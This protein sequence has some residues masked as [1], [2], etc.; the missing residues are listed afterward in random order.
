MKISRGGLAVE[1]SGKLFAYSGIADDIERIGNHAVSVV[2]LVRDKRRGNIEFTKWAH[3]EIDEIAGLIVQN[4]EDTVTLLDGSS[5]EL[6]SRIFSREDR[7]DRLVREARK[8]HQERYHTG[9]CQPDAGPIFVEMILRLER[10][11][12][13]CENIAEYARE[14]K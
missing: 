8:R 4:L 3:A 2:G 11:S 5:S 6:V 1:L 10:M 13:H 12:D 7:V 9:A 14:L